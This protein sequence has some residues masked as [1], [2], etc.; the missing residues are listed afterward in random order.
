MLKPLLSNLYVKLLRCIYFHVCYMHIQ[1][2]MT[3]L[4]IKNA[5]S[6]LSNFVE[7]VLIIS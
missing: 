6:G 7:L 5:E 3:S 4:N 1:C 2:V